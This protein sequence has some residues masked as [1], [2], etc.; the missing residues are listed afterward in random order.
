MSEQEEIYDESDIDQSDS[1]EENEN[2]CFF[3][4]SYDLLTIEFLDLLSSHMQG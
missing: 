4:N 1:E 2:V 3:F